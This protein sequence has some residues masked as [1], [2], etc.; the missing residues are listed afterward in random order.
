MRIMVR[1]LAVCETTE[2]PVVKYQAENPKNQMS[3]LIWFSS[4]DDGLLYLAM[5]NIY[6]A[7]I[8]RFVLHLTIVPN[9]KL[10]T[11]AFRELLRLYPTFSLPPS[12][13]FQLS[14]PSFLEPLPNL[15]EVIAALQL[16]LKSPMVPCA[17][18]LSYYT[19]IETVATDEAIAHT[20]PEFVAKATDNENEYLRRYTMCLMDDLEPLQS[21]YL[22]EHNLTSIA[23]VV[24]SPEQACAMG[25]QFNNLLPTEQVQM[26]HAIL[27]E[28]ETRL[29]AMIRATLERI[30]T[31]S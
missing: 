9:R 7:L 8:V 23:S 3:F 17:L 12:N 4:D 30:D 22:T 16:V 11:A 14:L 21:S 6:P 29:Y 31:I 15:P 13:D 24:R 25:K 10:H 26:I 1:A 27:N 28:E 2:V 19:S 20:M 5:K 18:D